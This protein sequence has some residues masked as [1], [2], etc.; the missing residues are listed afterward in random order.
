[1]Q[2]DEV[3]VLDLEAE[4]V[5]P[6][7]PLPNIHPIEAA[8]QTAMA[9]PVEVGTEVPFYNSSRYQAMWEELDYVRFMCL[10]TAD[11]IERTRRTPCAT[12]QGDFLKATVNS[13]SLLQESALKSVSLQHAATVR[14]YTKPN[15]AARP[16]PPANHYRRLTEEVLERKLPFDLE[17][18]AKSLS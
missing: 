14:E 18:N 4:G 2:D 15:K 8:I 10:R 5:P 17:R 1:M 9:V 7:V 6:P 12:I 13:M 3:E 16:P 11:L